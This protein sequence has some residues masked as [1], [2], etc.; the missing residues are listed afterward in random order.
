MELLPGPLRAAMLA[1]MTPVRNPR[2]RDVY[3]RHS[4]GTDVYFLAEGEAQAFL[5]APNGRE[6][7]VRSLGP[8]D[9]FGELAAL[10][11][12][13]RSTSI[14]AVTPIRLLKMRRADFLACIGASPAAALWLAERLGAEVRRL[15]DKVFELSALNVQ[16]RLHCEL[17][18][19]AR[20]G[21][22]ERLVIDPAPTHAELAARIGTHREAVTRELRELAGMGIIRSG[23]R[24]IEFLDLSGLERA[25]G[26]AVGDFADAAVI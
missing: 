13:P 4:L 22:G 15:T 7:P 18:R 10:D 26:R 19:L 20:E 11:G 14:T 25:V 12:R 3:T 1:K 9:L 17:L 6:V 8:G 23:R 24:S 16:A 21:R 2:G 5:L